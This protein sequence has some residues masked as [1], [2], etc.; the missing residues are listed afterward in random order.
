MTPATV[1]EDEKKEDGNVSYNFNVLAFV[2]ILFFMP[3]KR[4][5]EAAEELVKEILRLFR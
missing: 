3:S 5:P 4:K 1:V 2:P